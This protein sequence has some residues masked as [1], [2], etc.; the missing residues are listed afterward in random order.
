MKKTI[1]FAVILS[2]LLTSCTRGA[3]FPGD[4]SCNHSRG[5]HYA[6]MRGKMSW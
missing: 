5:A 2:L 4:S 1:L 3:W 6:K